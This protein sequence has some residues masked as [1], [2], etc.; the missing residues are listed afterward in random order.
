MEL[1]EYNVLDNKTKAC[2][3]AEKGYYLLSRYEG[4]YLIN[5]FYLHRFYV[6]VWYLKDADKLQKIITFQNHNML[7]PYLNQI[8]IL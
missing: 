5:L 2:L 1:H 8:R 3:L 7:D 4:Q 6:E